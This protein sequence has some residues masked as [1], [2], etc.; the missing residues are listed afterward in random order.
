MIGNQSSAEGNKKG[1]SDRKSPGSQHAE[2]QGDAKAKG[3]VAAGKE[4]V[5]R[6]EIKHAIEVRQNERND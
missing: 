1:K 4:A 5:R 6:P 2:R 3:H